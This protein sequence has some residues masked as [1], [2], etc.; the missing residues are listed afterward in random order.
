MIVGSPFTVADSGTEVTGFINELGVRERLRKGDSYIMQA[1]PY[2]ASR[3]ENEQ[4]RPDGCSFLQVKHRLTDP[5]SVVYP[6]RS[7]RC[8]LPSRCYLP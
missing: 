2:D 1:C 6:D 5:L 4:Q 8:C 3:A 7:S